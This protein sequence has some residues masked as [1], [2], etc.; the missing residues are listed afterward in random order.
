MT[1]WLMLFVWKPPSG[2]N[3]MRCGGVLKR[4]KRNEVQQQED[5]EVSKP[6]RKRNQQTTK[7]S[8][9]CEG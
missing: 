8:Q 3:W 6:L 5:R 7:K 2:S 4:K 9:P 1:D